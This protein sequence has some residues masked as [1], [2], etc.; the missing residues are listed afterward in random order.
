MHI[1]KLISEEL[2][3]RNLR[4]Q[5][6]EA[7]GSQLLGNITEILT[8]MDRESFFEQLDDLKLEMAVKQ[9]TSRTSDEDEQDLVAIS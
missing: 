3:E 1:R 2:K 8:C 4:D 6:F 7:L 5:Q 9:G